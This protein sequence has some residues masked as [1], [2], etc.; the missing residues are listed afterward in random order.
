MKSLTQT[1]QQAL[2]RHRPAPSAHEASQATE[3]QAGW[4]QL[5][6]QPQA[7]RRATDPHP[8][9]DERPAPLA[10]PGVRNLR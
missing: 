4:P 5:P 9:A 1:I 3:A 10:Q 2:A 7:R 8:W 6:D